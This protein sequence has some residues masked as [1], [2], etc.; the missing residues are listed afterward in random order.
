MIRWFSTRP[1]RPKH[2]SILI[3]STFCLGQ[4]CAPSPNSSLIIRP[5]EVRPQPKVT[6]ETS[7][8]SIT[9]ELFPVQAPLAVENFLTY[10]NN[11]F[12]KD[13]I[14]HAASSKSIAGG[15]YTAD[16]KPKTTRDPIL[17]ESNNGLSNLRGRIA[18]VEPSGAGSGTSQFVILLQDDRTRDYDLEKNAPGQTV[19]GRVIS[20]MDVADAIGKLNTTSS[21]AGDGT[22]LPTLPN[23]PPLITLA[24][25]EG[26]TP[27]TQPS[28]PPPTEEENRPP[29]A[30][31]QRS[32]KTA[33]GVTVRLDGT[34]SSDPDANDQLAYAWTQNPADAVQLSDPSSS[35]PSFVAPPGPLSVEFTLTVSD[36]LGKTSTA[37]VTIEV[38]AEPKVRLA[39]TK[40]DILL[41]MLV[42]GAPLT[43]HNF[44]QYVEDRFYDG[45]II[46][47]I[48]YL[49]EDPP[50]PF[51]IQGGGF[52]PNLTQP[53]GLRAAVRN[54]FSPD[55]SNVRGTVAMA[56][57][58]GDPD[59]ATSQ[60]FVNLRDN[61]ENL[62]N[63]N[64]GFTVF[65]NVVEGMD[66][67]D[68]IAAVE[69]G[70]R[71]NPQGNTFEDVPVE[72]IIVNTATIE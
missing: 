58:G 14:F 5:P 57:L 40:G 47:R 62:D 2:L 22:V 67:V 55:R 13:T 71:S 23:D 43:T 36:L 42:E 18:V 59:S 66:V 49:S 68:A 15:G 54:E 65:A 10:V 64:G 17:N 56:K 60:F 26:V 19:F 46:H 45:T 9:L 35:R 6:L 25:Q 63:Q 8:G 12:Y 51:V 11:G 4:Q 39:T 24:S 69:R 20:G 48:A 37:S 16:L 33:A 32:H 52:L 29:V 30:V 38:V 3:L 34:G 21:T 28:G 31:A 53:P 72:D 50:D 44:M 27:T 1:I 70:E 41:D 61:S 7:R